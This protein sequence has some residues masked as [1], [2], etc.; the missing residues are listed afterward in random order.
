MRGGRIHQ[1]A[2]KILEDRAVVRRLDRYGKL[3]RFHHHSAR[4]AIEELRAI[5]HE[6]FEFDSITARHAQTVEDQS[7][8]EPLSGNLLG[9]Q[10]PL[11]DLR[12]AIPE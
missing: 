5:S 6:L 9:L 8:I 7:V 2:G 3:A 10:S 11:E 4:P 12:L 1:G